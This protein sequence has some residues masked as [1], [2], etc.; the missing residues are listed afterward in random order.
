MWSSDLLIGLMAGLFLAQWLLAAA[1]PTETVTLYLDGWVIFKGVGSAFGVCLFGGAWAFHRTEQDIDYSWI[2]LGLTGVLMLS[3]VFCLASPATGL[4]GGFF[5]IA[6]LSLAVGFLMIPL[7]K[8][9]RRFSGL[10]KGPYLARLS[11]REAIWYPQDL[12]VALAGL[13]LAV[14]TAIGV[15]LMI[16]SF[17]Q[18]F[19]IGRAHV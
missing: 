2:A 8:R 12:S 5:S 4:A 15:G 11:V 18:D 9:L 13:T 6:V 3:A 7:L 14:A 16:D 17:R 19:E 1:L 10:V